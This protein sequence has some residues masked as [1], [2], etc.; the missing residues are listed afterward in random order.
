MGLGRSTL[1][2]K[3]KL[4]GDMREVTLIMLPHMFQNSVSYCGRN[5]RDVLVLVIISRRLKEP[6]D[7]TG[8]KRA[9]RVM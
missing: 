9:M 5:N 7:Q 8:T 1:V 3:A 6:Q 4:G 2:I